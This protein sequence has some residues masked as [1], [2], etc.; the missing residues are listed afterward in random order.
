M[1]QYELLATIKPNL[2]MEEV[3]KVIK[4][5][6]EKVESF[7]GKVNSVDKLGRK[8]LA[9]EIQNFRD[10]FFLV[11]KMDLDG[12]KVQELKRYIKLSEN[13]LRQMII[14][15]SNIKVKAEVK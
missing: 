10:G 9:Y 13:Y 1:K 7:G 2:D 5:L 15:A 4:K 11:V 12:D 6:E 8:K 3:D 14:D